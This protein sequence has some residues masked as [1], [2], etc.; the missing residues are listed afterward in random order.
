MLLKNQCYYY[1][2]GHII[3]HPHDVLRVLQELDVNIISQE[4]CQ[5]Q[6]GYGKGRVEV[7]DQIA[8]WILNLVR[9]NYLNKNNRTSS[10]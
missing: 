10:V 3:N 2:I 8:L 1:I 4:E 5:T 6:W 7:S 9:Y